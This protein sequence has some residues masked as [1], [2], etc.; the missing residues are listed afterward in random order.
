MQ[1]IKGIAV[2][3][4]VAICPAVVIDAEDQPIPRRTVIYEQVEAK[5]ARI[6]AALEASRVEVA[7]LRDEA[8]ES[9]GEDLAAIFGFHIGMLHDTQLLDQ[10][11]RMIETDMVTAEYA[12]YSVMHRLGQ[13]FLQSD[14]KLLRER[15]TDIWDLERRMLRHLAGPGRTD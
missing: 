1:I 5:L 3:P 14:S 10:V 12:V 8:A 2:S 13:Q 9:L 7:K 4:G 6:D 11:R 15:V